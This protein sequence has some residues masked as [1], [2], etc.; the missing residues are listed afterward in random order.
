MSEIQSPLRGNYKG[1]SVHYLNGRKDKASVVIA[2][3]I[4]I[5]GKEFGWMFLLNRLGFNVSFGYYRGT[6]L[7]PGEFLSHGEG[8]LSVTEDISDLIQFSLE[9]FGSTRVYI[10]A[11]SFGCLPSLVACTQ[12]EEVS[13][14]FMFGAPIRTDD[15]ELNRKYEV[16][17]DSAARVG[18]NLNKISTEGGYFFDG[19]TDL[20][21]FPHSL[22]CPTPL[23]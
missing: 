17:G 13:K 6:W 7:S 14:I 5:P 22:I 23:N 20:I 19:Y 9:K 16:G 11:Y 15:P 3:D 2:R 4:W 10:L 21:L 8:A 1:L 12:F 18:F